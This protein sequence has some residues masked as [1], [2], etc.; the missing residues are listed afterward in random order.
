MTSNEIPPAPAQLLKDIHGPEA[1]IFTSR[2]HAR[3]FEDD[4]IYH[5]VSR[6]LSGMALLVP[7]DD[8]NDM[9]A[10]VLG[11]V[12]QKNPQ[13]ELFAYAFLSN[14]FHLAVRGPGLPEFVGQLKQQISLRLKHYIDEPFETLWSGRYA[15][16]ALIVPE[17][18]ERCFEYILSHGVKEGLV[19][20]P[21]QWPG[22][23]CARDVFFGEASRGAWLNATTYGEAKRG[24]ERKVPGKRQKV[25][26][27][28]HTESVVITLTRLPAYAE[29]SP[30]RY[31]RAM[32][33][34]RERIIRHGE[35]LRGGEPAQ[36]V[37]KVLNLP[38]ST[39][40]KM[41]KPPWFRERKKMIVWSDPSHPET[42]AYL[43]RYNQSQI[44]FA[45]ASQQYRAGDR[46]VRFPPNM[47]VPP[48]A[49][50]RTEQ[51]LA[52]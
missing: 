40:F 10:G 47:Y 44:D 30:Q 39:L 22:V 7:R 13:V 35:T 46:N 1:K 6:V 43:E 34:L 45:L 25:S 38:R 23:H 3:Y 11:H 33:K 29:L 15:A 12:Q 32:A 20:K 14:H 36:G 31:R 51:R 42:R 49:P 50:S 5:V 8:I 28:D 52:A 9:I 26:R 48:I 24:E 17:D 2:H 27:A 21:E 37:D 41:P 18:Q 4:K 19:E 16:A